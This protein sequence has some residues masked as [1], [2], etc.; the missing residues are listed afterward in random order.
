MAYELTKGSI[1]NFNEFYGVNISFS[2]IQADAE[3][4]NSFN[5]A[6]Q[7][8]FQE[9]YAQVV[10]KDLIK[11]DGEVFLS[12]DM[13]KDFNNR[14]TNSF[15]DETPRS[16]RG[17]LSANMGIESSLI[18][19]N[20]MEAIWNTVPQ[21]QVDAVAE[22]YIKGNIR[23]RDM[24]AFSKSYNALSGKKNKTI[25][26]SYALA[27]K[28]VN[29][30]RSFLWK[31]FHPFRNHAEQRDAKNIAAMLNTERGSFAGP[32]FTQAGNTL[33]NF[34]ALEKETIDHVLKNQNL[35]EHR[36]SDEE[37]EKRIQEEFETNFIFE[38]DTTDEQKQQEYN[39]YRYRR[40]QEFQSDEVHKQQ[41]DFMTWLNNFGKDLEPVHE[42]N[43]NEKAIEDKKENII[44]EEAKEP[45]VVI[46]D[47]N[48]RIDD[49]LVIDDKNLVK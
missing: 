2:K 10:L 26:A 37:K 24:V 19:Y 25:L 5:Q 36:L 4:L 9:A 18:A 35:I 14:I 44:I 15:I 22:N 34:D 45:P 42:E 28:K 13:F 6:L 3:R 17:D 29:E 49:A 31:V 48:P 39:K 12:R 11:K 23:I 43:N 8:A 20:M 46:D 30:G 16:R 33:V 27:L 47:N 1:N 38:S 41:Q 21:N 32:D 7:I 40:M